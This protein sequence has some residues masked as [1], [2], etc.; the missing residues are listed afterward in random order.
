MIGM[1]AK[2]IHDIGK[3]LAAMLLFTADFEAHDLERTSQPT[4]LLKE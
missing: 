4:N 2:D 3:N 1:M